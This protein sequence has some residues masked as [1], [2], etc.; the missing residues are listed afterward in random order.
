MAQEHIFKQMDADLE[1]VRS[2]VLQMGGMVEEQITKSIEALTSGNLEL[3][4]E[5]IANDHRVNAL[6]M[7]IDGECTQIIARRQPTA[8]DLR[9]IMT[10]ERAITDLERIGDKAEKIARMAKKIHGADRISVPRFSEIRHMSEMVLEMLRTALDAFARLDTTAAA[11][12]KRQ[13]VEVDD[14][15]DAV[16]RHLITFMMEDPRMITTAIDILF[17]AKA[18]ERVG[19]H[20]KNIAGY[21]VY[22]A[23]GKDVR[24]ASMEEME[25]EIEQ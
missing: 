14:E 3:A 24:H 2:R 23:K 20:A 5:V 4:D 11:Q 22:M 7:L 25:R 12:L 21:V 18:V 8:G 1:E 6:E 10:V 17:A 16:L 19:D 15:F 13:D 9:L